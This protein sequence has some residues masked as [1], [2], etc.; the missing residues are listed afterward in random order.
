MVDAGV[1]LCISLLHN[2]ASKVLENVVNHTQSKAAESIKNGT[3]IAE[4]IRAGIQ[5]NFDEIKDKL[6][7]H[8]EVKLK[9]AKQLCCEAVADIAE[10]FDDNKIGL[11]YSVAKSVPQNRECKLTEADIKA[12][13]V[14]HDSCN[15][16]PVSQVEAVKIQLFCL[17][18]FH[19]N[20]PNRLLSLL[21][22]QIRS[23]G[24]NSVMKESL[25]KLSTTWSAKTFGPNK[26]VR[27][28]VV[29]LYQHIRFGLC[30]IENFITCNKSKLQTCIDALNELHPQ[31]NY[32]K[33]LGVDGVILSSIF[34]GR[35]VCIIAGSSFHY[36]QNSDKLTVANSPYNYTVDLQNLT[37]TREKLRLSQRIELR[38]GNEFVTVKN[39]VVSKTSNSVLIKLAEKNKAISI[40]F[41][42][43]DTEFQ[44]Q[45]R[46]AQN[47]VWYESVWSKI[48]LINAKDGKKGNSITVILEV[49]IKDGEQNVWKIK[50]FENGKIKSTKKLFPLHLSEPHFIRWSKQSACLEAITVDGIYTC[51]ITQNNKANSVKKFLSVTNTLSFMPRCLMNLTNYSFKVNDFFL[52]DRYIFV[53]LDVKQR[54][55]S[56]AEPT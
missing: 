45:F 25:M 14:F 9:V 33:R 23:I 2:A 22:L 15:C 3:V 41:A 40:P 39:H 44:A 17:T 1:N 13:E 37:A 24:E 20:D 27:A 29:N 50:F 56:D 31:K 10:K 49:K 46:C 19:H 18:V 32:E 4:H 42:T 26:T 53:A 54:R 43:F 47:T 38:N 28:S 51:Q 6:N 16:K 30:T 34:N 21:L 11:N 36:I 5:T 12:K 7:S 52:S 8:G 55:K 48:L 35:S